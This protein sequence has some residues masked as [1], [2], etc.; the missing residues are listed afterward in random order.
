MMHTEFFR[1]VETALRLLNVAFDA[2][3]LYDF[4]G[5]MW[6]LQEQE[7]SALAWGWA[8]LREQSPAPAGPAAAA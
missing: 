3:E 5:G 8:F 2:R 7:G 4:C 6:P 1:A